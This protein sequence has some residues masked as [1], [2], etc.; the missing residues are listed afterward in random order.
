MIA[1]F[2]AVTLANFQM[3]AKRKAWEDLQV[4]NDCKTRKEIVLFQFAIS[5]LFRKKNNNIFLSDN[6]L[7]EKQNY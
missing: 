1:F 5:F 2:S 3:I 6:Q 4:K 7:L